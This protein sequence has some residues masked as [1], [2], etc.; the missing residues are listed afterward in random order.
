MPSPEL[1][2]LVK[3]VLKVPLMLPVA[4]LAYELL[5]LSGKAYDT[6]RLARALAAPGLWLQ[7]ITTREPDDGQLEIACLSIRKALWREQQGV[8]AEA[9]VEVYASAADISLPVT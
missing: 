3:I 5:K 8:T 6:S 4:G 7:K 1:D 2:N 9:T